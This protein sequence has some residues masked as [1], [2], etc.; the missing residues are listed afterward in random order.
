MLLFFLLLSGGPTLDA[1]PSGQVPSLHSDLMLAGLEIPEVKAWH[2]DMEFIVSGF[3]LLSSARVRKEET[4]I[5][6]DGD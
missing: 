2:D 3:R 4:V 6:R 5:N 1:M